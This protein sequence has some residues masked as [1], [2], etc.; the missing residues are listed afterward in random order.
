V[1]GRLYPRHRPGYIAIKARGQVFERTADFCDWISMDPDYRAS[2][3]ALA[4]KFRDNA[5]IVLSPTKTEKAIDL[6]L[7]LDKLNN[8]SPLFE[9]LSD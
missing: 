4:G 8:L 5:E 3:E 9:T 7:N 1:E 2:D 6:I